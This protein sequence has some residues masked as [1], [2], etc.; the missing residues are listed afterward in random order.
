MEISRQD[1]RKHL[2]W[3]QWLLVIGICYLLY[4]NDLETGFSRLDLLILLYL[5]SHLPLFFIPTRYFEKRGFDYFLV[6]WDIVL[7]IISIFISRQA[8]AEFYLFF[9]LI[10]IMAAAAQN[11]R[12]LVLG[13]LV[14]SGL[15]PWVLFHTGE[16]A[17]TSGSL[18]R[19]PFL[20][21]VGLFFGY[22]VYL[23]QMK[24]LRLRAE[25]EFTE[26]L[27][28]FGKKLAQN[29]DP[30]VLYRRIPRLV[31]SIMNAD[32]CELSLIDDRCLQRRFTFGTPVLNLPP[33]EAANSVHKQVCDN[34]QSYQSA[35]FD[36]DPCF[37]DKQD[38]PL[39]P[40]ASYCAC[41]LK[42]HEGVFAILAIFQRQRKIWSEHELKKFQ[43]LSEQSSLSLE[44]AGL[45]NELESKARTDGLTGLF[46]HRYF[47][48]RME[49]EI[50]RARRKHYGLSVVMLDVD[51]FK[52]INDT[53][54]HRA[55]DEVLR[56]VASLLRSTT[57]QM[58][59][60]A[61]YGGDEF[62]L[63]LPETNADQAQVLFKRILQ[64]FRQLD[65]GEIKASLS[66][67]IASY[68]E[69]GQTVAGLIDAA[70][71]A[72][73]QAKSTGRDRLLH[74]SQSNLG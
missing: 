25:S 4:F 38:F 24:E 20:F 70:D 8:T 10:L 74:H 47:H 31:K 27:F 69:H 34:P 60:T 64:H 58:D 35:E 56:R 65:F 49:E 52:S 42:I 48:D 50:S 62:V 73:Y 53:W 26:D 46:N 6:L 15:Y 66:V 1:R 30:E 45:L 32:L 29:W 41:R 54:G 72:L 22:M 68:P 7:V 21:I 23:Q 28:E 39:Y 3:L 36:S 13:L 63:V 17:L 19:V 40:F 5:G 71:R 9:F 51:H 55:G 43:F 33:L 57:R 2:L 37:N 61:R 12:A 18:L 59:V 11:L 16:F 44:H 67:G 14:I